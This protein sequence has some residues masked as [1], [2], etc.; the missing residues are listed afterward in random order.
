MERESLNT[1]IQSPHFQSRSGT[2]NHTGGTRSYGGMVDYQRI[3]I[4]ELHLG[5]FSD[6]VEFQSW[7]VNFKTEVFHKN[8]RSSDQCAVDQRS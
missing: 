3:L 1:L 7:K 4:T 8:S 5:K 6:P 2:L